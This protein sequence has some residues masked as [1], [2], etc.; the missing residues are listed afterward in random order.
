[1]DP[2]VRGYNFDVAEGVDY[3]IDLRRPYGERVVN[4]RFRGEPLDPARKLRLAIN[5]YRHN[6]GGGY[7][8]YKDTPVLLR[9]S[10]EVRDLIIDWVEKHGT[11]PAEPTNNWRLLPES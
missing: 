11:V 8:M 1:V 5:N 6:G 3:E 4:L 9:S 2:R 7:T 10:A